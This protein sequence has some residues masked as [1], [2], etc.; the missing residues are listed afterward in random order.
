MTTRRE[1]IVQVSLGSAALMAA[2]HSLGAAGPLV[3][4]T[5]P[6]AV[7]LGYK[8]VAAKADKAKFPKY[9][10]GQQCSNCALYQGKPGEPQGACPL[11]V[12]KE[13]LAGAWCSAYAKKPA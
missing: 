10:D 1:F 13:V 11:Y 5:D 8:S 3:A 4:E 12:G 7:T 6:L 9:A 2:G